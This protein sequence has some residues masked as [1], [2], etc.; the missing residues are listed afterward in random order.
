[1]WLLDRSVRE[2]ERPLGEVEM[3]SGSKLN[4]LQS[5]MQVF[6]A[7]PKVEEGPELS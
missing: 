4:S 5:K 2:R 3:E 6:L 7:W 1:M